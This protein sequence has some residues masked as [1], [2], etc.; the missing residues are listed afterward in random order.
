MN[1]KN[2][3]ILIVNCESLINFNLLCAALTYINLIKN[4][5]KT[6]AFNLLVLHWC[7][8][9]NFQKINISENMRK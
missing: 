6:F 3:I 9:E 7:T 8:V 1:E 2:Q 5:K 4:Y